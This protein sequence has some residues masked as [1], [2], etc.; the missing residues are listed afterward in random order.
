MNTAPQ[1]SAPQ[2]NDDDINLLE[3]LRNIWAGRW[4]V[5]LCVVLGGLF[6]VFY[7]LQSKPMY[8]SDSLL[9]I[10]KRATS[11]AVP[12]AMQD[13]LGGDGGSP[14]ETE[15]EIIR[16]RLVLG[17]AVRELN[18]EIVAQ[19]KELP[20]VGRIPARLKLPDPGFDFLSAY[21]WGNERISVASLE[22]PE[23]WLVARRPDYGANGITLTI[24]GPATFD[25]KL[26]DQSIHSGTVRQRLRVNAAEFSILV[27]ELSGPTGREFS[28]HRLTLEMA[29]SELKKNLAASESTRNS[30]MLRLSLLDPDP[31]QSER[32]LDAVAQAYVNQNLARSAAEADSSLRFIEEQLPI[33]QAEVNEAQVALND[34]REQERSV[35]VE[36]ETLSLLQQATEIESRLTELRLEEESIRQKYTINHPRY[37]VLLENRKSLEDLLAATQGQSANLPE[38]QKVIFNLTR[39]LEVAQE[40]YLQLV[41]R[42]QELRVLKASTIGSARIVDTAYSDGVKVSPRS[43]TALAG[44]L[45]VSGLFGVAIVLFRR[46]SFKG[47]RGAKDLEDKGIAVFG[48]LNFV[49]QAAKNRSVKG[50][51]GIHVLS[52]PDDL[53]AESL[54]SLRTSLHFGMIDAK[55][56]IVQLT[57]ARPSDGKSFVSTNL[58]VILAQS[59]MKVC[60]VDSDLRRGYLCRYFGKTRETPGLSDILSQQ[61]TI[62][63]VILPGPV[64]GMSVILTGR[65]PPNP[66]ELLMRKDFETLLGELNSRF[67]IVVI[68]SAPVLAVTDPAIIGRYAGAT[69]LVVRHIESDMNEIAA[70]Q[71]ALMAAGVKLSGGVLNQYKPELGKKFGGAQHYN[72]RYSYKSES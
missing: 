65:Y 29:I 64:D 35:D 70:A 38:T 9:Q 42:A 13:L 2:D 6:G 28:L 41:N 4:T 8:R 20:L 37:Q 53:L 25:V 19:P 52:Y 22:V 27:D 67:D 72:Y 66:S 36:Y 59:G 11:L 46:W 15:L 12:E 44:F 60:L 50:P 48:T 10:E 34:Y 55:M 45:F 71:Q 21:R 69:V 56:N 58:S 40:A 31:T 62:D 61:K 54:R 47:V 57:S 32:V 43:M 3:L 1:T 18:L 39:D 14:V 30:S 16:S 63:E 24:T 23:H 26:P 33:T 49:P 17:E 5:V 51:L 68:D 7:V